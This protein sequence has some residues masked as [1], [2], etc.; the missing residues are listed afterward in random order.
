MNKL[1]ELLQQSIRKD[2][3]TIDSG[4]TVERAMEILHN[5]NLTTLVIEYYDEDSQKLYKIVT[6]REIANC[7]AKGFSPNKTVIAEIAIS[8]D[9]I[10]YDQYLDKVNDVLANADDIYLIQRDNVIVGVATSEG[11]LSDQTTCTKHEVADVFYSVHVKRGAP[12]EAPR[13]MR[14][15]YQIA[16][17]EH[18]SEWVCFE[19]TGYTRYRAEQWWLRRANEPV[20]ASAEEAVE[21]AHDGALAPT[22]AILV[23]HKADEKFDRVVA[24]QLGEKPG[25]MA[26]S[27]PECLSQLNAE[28]YV[29]F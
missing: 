23:E 26:D 9:V 1:E 14:V 10:E 6:G 5:E 16:L 19:H 29:P 3:T 4:I 20:P 2:F 12:P 15:D 18:V 25:P 11:I 17:N 24:Y 8:S 13:T 27:E 22:I 7:I 28:D 21:L